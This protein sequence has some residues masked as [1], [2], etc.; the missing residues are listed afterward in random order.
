VVRMSAEIVRIPAP[1]LLALLPET[2]PTSDSADQSL[3]TSSKVRLRVLAL[4][5]SSPALEILLVRADAARTIHR[6]FNRPL[7]RFIGECR[8]CV[9]KLSH[10]GRLDGVD[11]SQ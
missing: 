9:V 4:R 8:I 11:L 5:S 1:S 7:R 10:K 3:A 6:N 2:L